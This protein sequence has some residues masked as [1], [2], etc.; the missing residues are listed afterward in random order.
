MSWIHSFVTALDTR[1]VTGNKEPILFRSYPAP[2]SE[3]ELQQTVDSATIWEAIRATTAAPGAFKPATI[4]GTAFLDAAVGGFNDPGFV[5]QSQAKEIWPGR[6]IDV[7]LSLG[8]GKRNQLGVMHNSVLRGG[9]DLVVA[10]RNIVSG[11][12]VI[13]HRI[14][15]ELG[16]DVFFHFNVDSGL[17]DINIANWRMLTKLETLTNKYLEEGESIGRIKILVQNI[18]NPRP[19]ESS[20]DKGPMYVGNLL[21]V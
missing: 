17:G 21:S 18:V 4:G 16:L 8:T 2:C 9:L 14:A 10:F 1:R 15:A 20:H 13:T 6:K 7:F 3:P 12:E 19:P 5:V 11:S